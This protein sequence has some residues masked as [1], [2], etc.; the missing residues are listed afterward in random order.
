MAPL[1]AHASISIF[2]LIFF[3]PALIAAI[4]LCTKHGIGRSSGWFFLVTVSL[5]RISGAATQ[6]ATYSHPTVGL[7][8]ASAILSSFGLSTLIL[9]SIGFLSR[10]ADSSSMMRSTI[11]HPMVYRLVQLLVTVGLIVVIVGDSSINFD[12]QNGGAINIPAEAKAGIIIILAA[13]VITASI[14]VATVANISKI[15]ETERL[16]AWAVLVA[17]PFILV[18]LVYGILVIFLNDKHF[19]LLAPSTYVEWVMATIEECFVVL[20]YLLVGFKVPK[21]VAAQQPRSTVNNGGAGVNADTFAYL[22][23][24]A[25]QQQSE[26]Q[27]QKIRWRGTPIMT[28]IGIFTDMHGNRKAKR[29]REMRQTLPKQSQQTSMA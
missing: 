6:L 20:L 26:P 22:P 27:R 13:W 17:L 10:S 5:F 24:T 8:T 25:Q 12:S 3:T 7:F 16:L 14:T 11:L 21:I 19:N 15:V 1:N 28:L 9:A 29:E 2:Q 18:R 4:Y 23:G